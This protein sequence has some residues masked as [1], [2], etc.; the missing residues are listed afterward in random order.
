MTEAEKE[1]MTEAEKE[2]NQRALEKLKLLRAKLTATKQKALDDEYFA[3]ADAEKEAFAKLRDAEKEQKALDAD[4]DMKK[5]NEMLGKGVRQPN[6][7]ATFVKAHVKQMSG[8]PQERMKA[9]AKLWQESK[10]KAGTVTE[11][12]HEAIPQLPESPENLQKNV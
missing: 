4:A 10:K 11:Q 9:V 8:N 7:Y 12:P 3:E 2:D 5:A 6:A 1:D